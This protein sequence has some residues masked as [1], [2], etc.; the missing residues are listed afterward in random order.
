MKNVKVKGN[1]EK[2]YMLHDGLVMWCYTT[3]YLTCVAAVLSHSKAW[4][5]MTQ[6][7][8]R[9][10][11]PSTW[12]SVLN[13]RFPGEISGL[14]DLTQT[15]AG[16]PVES[17]HSHLLLFA[18][19]ASSTSR[20]GLWCIDIGSPSSAPSPPSHGFTHRP[21]HAGRAQLSSR[22]ASNHHQPILHWFSRSGRE[23][24]W[25]VCSEHG[26]CFLLH[27]NTKLLLFCF[28][29]WCVTS[30]SKRSS[31]SGSSNK[32][33]GCST[34]SIAWLGPPPPPQ[35]S[36][37]HSITKICRFPSRFWRSVT[38]LQTSK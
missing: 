5:H 16:S 10:A 23:R 18:S 28:S 38:A 30:C 8:I 4:P 14:F 6:P 13:S 26:V 27:L 1:L 25:R 21:A 11:K 29:S 12:I 3:Y 22:G 35:P 24:R 32:M 2:T 9:S 31:V 36:A 33:W 15:K 7:H 17:V 34:C 20:A 37:R 19:T